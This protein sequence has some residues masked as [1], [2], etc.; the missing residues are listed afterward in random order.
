VRLTLALLVLLMPGWVYLAGAAAAAQRFAR[1]PLPRPTGFPPVSVLKPLYG[2]E[3]GLYQNLRSFAEQ[4]YPAPQLVLGVGAAE[5][6]ALPVARRLIHDLPER[7]I[8][9]TIGAGPGANGKVANLETMLPAATGRILVL[10]DSDMRVAGDYLAAVTAPLADPRIGIVTCLYRGVPVGGWWSVLGALHINF[11]FLP[12]AL[13][14]A[15]LGLGDGCFGA[16]IALER[17]TLMAIG[18]FAALRDQLADDHRLG[19]A[20]RAAGLRIHLSRYLVEARIAEPSLAGLWRHE[21]RWARTVRDLAPFGYVGSLL[22]Q[23]LA[24]AVCGAAATRFSLASCALLAITLLLRRASARIIAAALGLAT[25]GLWLL[26][27]RDILSFAVFVAGLFGRK[28]VWRDRRYRVEPSGRIDVDADR[29]GGRQR[30][31]P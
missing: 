20:V 25:N 31:G 12:S 11:G 24:L 22:A 29:A 5:D 28:V 3:P 30:P 13:V 17:D 7:D 6:G 4:D 14:G 21:L 8:R 19:A 1:R 26:P 27:A 18:D 2:A 23:P 16:T 15:A 9:L 10:A